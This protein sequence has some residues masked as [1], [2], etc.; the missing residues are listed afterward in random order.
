MELGLTGRRAI[1]TGGSK[2]IGLAIARELAMEGAAVAICSRD[3]AELAVAADDIASVSL[4]GAGGV[5]QQV[6]DVTD[7]AQV[8]RSTL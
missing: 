7:P 2:G 4:L 8:R 3:G 6:T 5:H 1:I